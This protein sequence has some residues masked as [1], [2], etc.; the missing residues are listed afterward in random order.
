ML[1]TFENYFFEGIELEGEVG[2]IDRYLAA[3]GPGA[4]LAVLRKSFRP[5]EEAAPPKTEVQREGG[6]L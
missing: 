3:A 1:F 5:A 4:P 6:Q 2:V